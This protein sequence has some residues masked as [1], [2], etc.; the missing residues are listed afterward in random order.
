MQQVSHREQAWNQQD[1]T[2]FRKYATWIQVDWKTVK[3]ELRGG[4]LTNFGATMNEKV[5]LKER[6]HEEEK[7]A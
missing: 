1:R 2:A 4:Y 3:Y 5:N 7:A 6:T